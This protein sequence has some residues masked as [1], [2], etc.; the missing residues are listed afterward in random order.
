MGTDRLRWIYRAYRYRYKLEKQEIR[1]LLDQLE[2]GDVAVD[3][4]AHKG[5]YTYWM[6]KAVGDSGRVFAFEPQPVLARRLQALAGSGG[7]D[8]VVVENLGVSSS[9]G[10]MQLN[11]PGTGSSPGASLE[12]GLGGN[13]AHSYPVKVVTLDDY[14][15]DAMVGCI[16]LIKCDAEGHELE[17]FRGGER[18]LKTA[19]PAL[20]FECERRH[21]ASGSVEEVFS[22]LESL[23][24]RGFFVDRD[25]L[26]DI[27]A[28]KPDLH[29]VEGRPVYINNFL[30]IVDQGRE[31]V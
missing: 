14:F 18:L 8:N 19:R 27:S 26:K 6:R 21:R 1:L 2:P 20:L 3:V 12:P 17:V 22:Y 23:G 11:V 5:A 10:T 24:F 4:G 15:D 9:A 7:L 16:R 30:F 31:V 13:H 28:F 25:G 29:Q